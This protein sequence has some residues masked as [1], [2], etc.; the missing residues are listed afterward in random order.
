MS[1]NSNSRPLDLRRAHENETKDEMTTPNKP[2][3]LPA[4]IAAR[5]KILALAD[6]KVSLTIELNRPI[7]E[8]AIRAVELSALN[9]P[10]DRSQRLEH[11]ARS[12]FAAFDVFESLTVIEVLAYG[13]HALALAGFPESKKDVGTMREAAA[14][15]LR[16]MARP[17]LPDS[18]GSDLETVRHGLGALIQTEESKQT[19]SVSARPMLLA[20]VDGYSAADNLPA[21]EVATL[22][23]EQAAIFAQYGSD[24]I[25]NLR[26][27]ALAAA[28]EAEREI[29]RQ[30]AKAKAE[31]EEFLRDAAEEKKNRK[32]TL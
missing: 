8:T 3:Q 11:A 28:T 12:I 22:G 14:T 17:E 16:A 24:A 26:A 27:E 18:E 6:R 29:E 10:E 31:R 20:T 15:L 13:G 23:E 7:L 2:G 5:A 19:V 25:T 21:G 9:A 1:R 32:P 30:R 4:E